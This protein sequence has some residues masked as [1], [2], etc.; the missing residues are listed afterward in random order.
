MRRARPRRVR[1]HAARAARVR[2]GGARSERVQARPRRRG[3]RSHVQGMR[4]FLP[5]RRRHVDQEPSDPRRIS[6]VR[7]ARRVERREPRRAP[8]H[9]RRRRGEPASGRRERSEGRPLLQGVHGRSRDRGRRNEA[10][11]AHARRHR[12]D[13]RYGGAFRRIREAREDRRRRPVRDRRR[14]RSQGQLRGDLR[15]RPGRPRPPEPRLL[16]RRRTESEARR[17]REARREPARAPRRRARQSRRGSR[18]RPHPRDVAREGIAHERPA[19]RS[20]RELPPH[21]ICR[22]REARARRQMA[23]LRREPRRAARREPQRRASGVPQSRRHAR[24]DDAAPRLASVSPRAPRDDVRQH[25]AEGVR[26]RELRLRRELERREGVAAA[27]EAMYVR[28]G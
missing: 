14:Q 16:F 5:L 6:V 7:Q 4:R 1:A 27:L 11:R 12:R 24:H 19:P 13:R 23:E 20:R 25:V 8:R 9:P 2:R 3:T 18:A 26:R 21:G 17:V 22:F 28:D 15:D 10:A